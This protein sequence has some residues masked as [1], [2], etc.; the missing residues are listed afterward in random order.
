MPSC[1]GK[2]FKV[3][4]F[5]FVPI[6]TLFFDLNWQGTGAILSVASNEYGTCNSQAGLQLYVHFWPQYETCIMGFTARILFLVLTPNFS[7]S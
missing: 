1:F 7:A 3:F 4:L 2:Q 5:L 6:K